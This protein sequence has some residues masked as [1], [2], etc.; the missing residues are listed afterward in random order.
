[1]AV[2]Q[3]SK[4]TIAQGLPRGSKFWDGITTPDDFE[5]IST[6]LLTT[7]Q[8]SVTF[9][10]TSLSLNYK[11]LQIRTVCRNSGGTGIGAIYIQ[12]NND[13]ASN[14]SNHFLGGYGSGVSSSA[15]TNATSIL[16]DQV[17]P[18]SNQATGSFGI[19]IIDIIDAFN[20]S[21][22]KTSRS[23]GGTSGPT[24]NGVVISSGNWRNNNAITSIKLQ[25]FSDSWIS[26]SRFSLY[27]IKG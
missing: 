16:I 2:R 24:N 20:T 11:H 19:G 25:P 14:Y 18:W 23:I 15:S 26:G 10:V 7:T 27:G 17:S 1:M 8:T 6:T 4:S 12:F 22:F 9:D 21:K 5:L 3:L 13:S